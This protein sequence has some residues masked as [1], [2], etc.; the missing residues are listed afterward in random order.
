MW[1]SKLVWPQCILITRKMTLLL[2]RS[3]HHERSGFIQQFHTFI[4]L[5]HQIDSVR[6]LKCFSENHPKTNDFFGWIKTSTCC[7]VSR[8]RS[9]KTGS[10]RTTGCIGAAL[11][12]SSLGPSNERRKTPLVRI[13]RVFIWCHESWKTWMNSLRKW[14][15]FSTDAFWG[16]ALLRFM[17]KAGRW[18]RRCVSQ[19]SV[20]NESARISSQRHS[21]LAV[22]A[23]SPT[24]GNVVFSYGGF[25]AKKFEHCHWV[26]GVRLK[27]TLQFIL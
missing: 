4:C 20:E 19:I 2:M 25:P 11:E 12:R 7:D 18:M 14:W 16:Q 8:N 9:S 13:C 22:I 1:F 15:S 27:E 3:H 26:S 24:G 17:T 5:D 6:F 21:A 10:G 23:M